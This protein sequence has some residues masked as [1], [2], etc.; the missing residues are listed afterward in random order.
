MSTSAPLRK[1]LLAP[2]RRN[3]EPTNKKPALVPSAVVED[4][5]HHCQALNQEGKAS[6]A[7]ARTKT[8]HPQK[9]TRLKGSHSDLWALQAGQT[10]LLLVDFLNITCWPTRAETQ[11]GGFHPKVNFLA[12]AGSHVSLI[13][14]TH[15]MDE[16]EQSMGDTLA[17]H[18]FTVFSVPAEATTNQDICNHGVTAA[19]VRTYLN[20]S[21]LLG[22]VKRGSVWSQS[23][24]SYFAGFWLHLKSSCIL[25]GSG[26][27]RGGIDTTE[28]LQVFH[29]IRKHSQD[30]YFPVVIG[31]DFNATPQEVKDSGWL[32]TLRC[33]LVHTHRA[34]CAKR[35]VDFFLVS[36]VLLEAVAG[37]QDRWD[38]PCGPHCALRLALRR[39]KDSLSRK[40]PVVPRALPILPE[41]VVHSPRAADL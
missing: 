2:Q 33:E 1:K 34:T 10:D 15:T 23:D 18:K 13:A 4:P 39:D 32:Q 29:A 11:P 25:L 7:L 22:S 3:P 12:S 14:E 8:K 38:V 24:S 16:G 6:L 40:V 27:C 37:I 41:E 28:C 9:V 36:T 35:T 21:P 5:D 17:R 19:L 20:T 26:Y 30:G 31:C